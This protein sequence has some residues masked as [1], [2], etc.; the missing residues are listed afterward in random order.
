MIKCD[1]L[2]VASY[3]SKCSLTNLLRL[4]EINTRKEEVGW[5]SP[6]FGLNARLVPQFLAGDCNE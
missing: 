6:D 5:V 2:W 1:Q 4:A 3:I